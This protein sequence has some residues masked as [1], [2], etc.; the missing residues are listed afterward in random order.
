MEFR[1]GRATLSARARGAFVAVVLGCASPFAAADPT[2][3]VSCVEGQFGIGGCPPYGEVIFFGAGVTGPNSVFEYEKPVLDFSPPAPGGTLRGVVDLSQALVRT[4]AQADDDGNPST[5]NGASMN[6]V[7]VDLFTLGAPSPDFFTFSVV[8]TA[9]G[10][11][12]IDVPDYTVGSYLSIRADSVN[13]APLGFSGG[14]L[15]DGKVL[16]AG[17]H[18]PVFQQ[19]N[20]NLMTFA[21]LSARLDQPF[22]LSFS[23]RTDVS[24]R[25]FLDFMHTARIGFVLPE[26]VTVTSM[27]GY[28]SAGVP[29]IPEPSTWLLMM[30]AG[31][32]ATVRLARSRRRD[33]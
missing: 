8:F 3:P 4:Y 5:N 27:G 13:G 1:S 14:K 23:L 28:D 11:G 30:A 26:G 31:L 17:S 12:G 20:V 33:V 2:G 21:N 22:L 19:F 9:E 32:A 7:G 6:A 15:D 18:V 16:Q 10:V 24:E 29:A 25:S